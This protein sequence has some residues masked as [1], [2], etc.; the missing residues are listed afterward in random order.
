MLNNEVLLDLTMTRRSWK[1]IPVGLVSFWLLAAHQG[2]YLVQ[3]SDCTHVK[4][5]IVIFHIKVQT[6]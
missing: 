1:I 6:T 5:L 4:P 3:D 2:H